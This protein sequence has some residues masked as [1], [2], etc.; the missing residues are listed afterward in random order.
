VPAG[1]GLRVPGD[2]PP[3]PGSSTLFFTS[4]HCFFEESQDWRQI[5]NSALLLRAGAVDLSSNISC[6]LS[7]RLPFHADKRRLDLALVS[8]WPPVQ[9]PPSTL[10]AR[11]FYMHAPVALAGFS[12]GQHLLPALS[13]FLPAPSDSDGTL[14]H[15][16]FAL[17]A[18]FTSI[19]SSM[20]MPANASGAAWESGVHGLYMEGDDGAPNWGQAAGADRGFVGYKPEKGLS[21]GAVLDTS[22]NLVGIIERRSLWAPSGSFVRLT[23]QVLK[24]L[25]DAVCGASGAGASA[26]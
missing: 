9:M 14:K 10:S 21:G 17:H 20:P 23:A 3:P 18:H 13:V 26:C 2:P 1:A 16:E 19:A 11:P 25:Q 4:A 22:C 6:V 7:T 15:T 8:C 5:G 12:L 24:L